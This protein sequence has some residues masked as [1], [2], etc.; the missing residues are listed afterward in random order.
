M[1]SNGQ[2]FTIDCY[3]GRIGS[4]NFTSIHETSIYTCI[5]ACSKQTSQRCKAVVF[6]DSMLKGYENCYLLNSTGSPNKGTN[7]TFAVLT[8]Y[9]HL[10][11]SPNINDKSK[12]WIAGPVIGV[13]AFLVLVAIAILYWHRRRVQSRNPD[14]VHV[15]QQQPQLDANKTHPSSAVSEL[16]GDTS[17]QWEHT[18]SFRAT[19]MQWWN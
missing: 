11:Q 13:V 19:R 4:E 14:E 3:D 10:D 16:K 15:P 17:Q 8:E 6:D 7:A 5:D 18:M 12:A 2:N 1:S 9:R